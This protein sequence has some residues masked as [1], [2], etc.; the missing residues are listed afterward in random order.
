MQIGFEASDQVAQVQTTLFQAP[1]AQ[2][3]SNRGG[4]TV[5]DQAVQIGVFHAQLDEPSLR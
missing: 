2:V 4:R 3:V 1:Q 5:V